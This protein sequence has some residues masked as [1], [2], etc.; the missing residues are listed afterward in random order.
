MYRLADNAGSAFRP[1]KLVG[2]TVCNPGGICH[3]SAPPVTPPAGSIHDSSGYLCGPSPKATTSVQ[4]DEPDPRGGWRRDG[5]IYFWPFQDTAIW[6]SIQDEGGK[7]DLNA[8]PNALL[9]GPLLS[10]QWEGWVR[11]SQEIGQ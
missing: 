5:T 6:V 11:W 1:R 10:A 2:A 8:S 7:I 4:A 3:S 9:R